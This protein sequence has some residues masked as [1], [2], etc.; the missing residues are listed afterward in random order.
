VRASLPAHGRH[1]MQQPRCRAMCTTAAGCV[2]VRA[3]GGTEALARWRTV[4]LADALERC[5]EVGES[6]EPAGRTDEEAA[7]AAA[8]IR[9]W[10]GSLQGI[11]RPAAISIT[12]ARPHNIASNWRRSSRSAACLSSWYPHDTPSVM[13]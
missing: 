7:A 4:A 10:E 8:D 1:T 12:N 5:D 6:P 2:C 3:Y 9:R 13:C 11:C